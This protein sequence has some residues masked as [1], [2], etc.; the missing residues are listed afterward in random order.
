MRVLPMCCAA[1]NHVVVLQ[2]QAIV[3]KLTGSKSS[4]TVCLGCCVWGRC[5]L[6]TSC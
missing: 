3:G 5:R 6:L 4:I 2:L 1:R